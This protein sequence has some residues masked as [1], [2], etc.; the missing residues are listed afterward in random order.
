VHIHDL[1][2]LLNHDQLLHEI[3][4]NCSFR[5]CGFSKGPIIFF[6]MYKNDLQTDEHDSLEKCC[7]PA[8]CDRV[9]WRSSDPN[10]VPQLHYQQYEVNVSDHCP[11]SAAF[12]VT[13]KSV[14][15]EV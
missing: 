6:L 7:L 10:H 11:I 4:H 1:A 3:K 2:T 5:F 8:W 9:L 12:T 15:H 14:K 13:V